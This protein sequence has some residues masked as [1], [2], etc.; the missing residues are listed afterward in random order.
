MEGD[1]EPPPKDGL[2]FV[3]STDFKSMKLNIFFWGGGGGVPGFGYSTR[4]V[5]DRVM[6]K[7]WS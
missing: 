4:C 5:E 7:T 6:V 3:V 1:W 2:V